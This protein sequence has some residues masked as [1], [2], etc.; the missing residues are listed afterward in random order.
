MRG[1]CLATRGQFQCFPA[2]GTNDG[3]AFRHSVCNGIGEAYLLRKRSTSGIERCSDDYFIEI[4]AEYFHCLLRMSALILSLTMGIRNN[5]LPILLSIRGRISFL[6]I[7][8]T[9]SGTHPMTRGLISENDCA[10]ILGDGIRVRKYRWAPAENRI[11]IVHHT[12]YMSQRQ[13]GYNMVARTY[14]EASHGN[15]QHWTKGCDRGA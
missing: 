7:F 3:A 5:S 15:M 6:I 1:G 11:K 10:I 14:R 8:S 9:I 13:H 4:T 12:K 2:A